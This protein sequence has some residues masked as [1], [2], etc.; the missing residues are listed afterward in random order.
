M[1]KK[2][3]MTAAV[4]ATSLF[5]LS[6]PAMA[7]YYTTSDGAIVLDIPDKT[8]EEIP[9]E[10]T[11]STLS[12]GTGTI[13]VLHYNTNDTLPTVIVPGANYAASYQSVLADKE[14][15]YVI[16]GSVTDK[17]YLPEV[18]KIVQSASY[19][20]DI[21]YAGPV[22]TVPTA[23]AETIPT[24][25]AETIP[26]GTVITN[27]DVTA[28]L[29]QAE[30][31][32]A[33]LEQKLLEDASLTQMDMNNLSYEIYMV[34]DGVLNELWQAMNDTFDEATMDNYLNEQMAWIATKESE[35]QIAGEAYAGG[36][37]AAMASNQ[38]AAELTKTRVYELA[39]YLT[40]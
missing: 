13:T 26:A 12:N 40:N 28:A 24:T 16:T 29:S 19:Y 23:P 25:P 22:E 34:W 10:Q 30:Q 9:D 3:K 2:M 15:I 1:N 14:D 39:S 32:A 21:P 31:N 27:Y 35:V 7:E 38:K 6:V 4:L 20:E 36:S 11:V 8:W 33:A 37:M 5:A 17:V 18:R